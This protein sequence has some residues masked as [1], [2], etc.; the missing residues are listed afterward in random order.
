[1]LQPLWCVL[2]IYK[3]VFVYISKKC[4]RVN[5]RVFYYATPNLIQYEICF[6]MFI[7]VRIP[8]IFG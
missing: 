8:N 7:K 2:N 5:F 4:F 3:Q 6:L 1:M